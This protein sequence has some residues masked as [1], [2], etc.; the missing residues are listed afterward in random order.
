M[1]RCP[2]TLL[3]CLK[4]FAAHL[5]RL[6]AEPTEREVGMGTALLQSLD[7]S[8]LPTNGHVMLNGSLWPSWLQSV[9]SM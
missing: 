4:A 9:D 5:R 3:T 7:V 2:A 6:P 8:I 1:W